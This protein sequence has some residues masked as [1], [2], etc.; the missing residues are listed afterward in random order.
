MQ[1]WNRVKT[2]LELQVRSLEAD[3][4]LSSE[5]TK[6][7]STQLEAARKASVTSTSATVDASDQT[8][9]ISELE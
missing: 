6:S 7:L 4:K 2:E 1:E 5:E 9:K 3:V 8:N